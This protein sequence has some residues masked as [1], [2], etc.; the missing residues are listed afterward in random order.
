MVALASSLSLAA[1]GNDHAELE[2]EAEPLELARFEPLCGHDGPV[3]LFAP[4]EGEALEQRWWNDARWRGG[5]LLSTRA[6]SGEACDPFL[7]SSGASTQALYWI[8][9]CGEVWQHVVLDG[10]VRVGPVHAYAEV[11]GCG[12]DGN[13]AVIDLEEATVRTIAAGLGCRAVPFG[14]GALVYR[15]LGERRYELVLLPSLTAPEPNPISLN[16]IVHEEGRPPGRPGGDDWVLLTETSELLLLDATDQRVVS[17]DVDVDRFG[18]GD[19][20]VVWQEKEAF[21]DGLP[22]HAIWLL[23]L[24][25]GERLQV[26]W[27]TLFE[28][29]GIIAGLAYAHADPGLGGSHVVFLP[30]LDSKH[31][32]PGLVP[33][34]R[35]PDDRLLVVDQNTDALALYDFETR[36]QMHVCDARC[37]VMSTAWGYDIQRSLG[38]TLGHRLM[39]FDLERGREIEAAVGYDGSLRVGPR[40]VLATRGTLEGHG[41]L[42]V[43][44]EGDVAPRLIADRALSLQGPRLEVLPAASSDDPF[45]FDRVDNGRLELW[46]VALA[47]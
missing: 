30:E 38:P 43:F 7:S 15:P 42:L 10:S 36:G 31:V 35:S 27:G 14:R 17:I 45:L 39:R 24:A 1:C 37:S 21:V 5:R 28:T 41:D 13:L 40:R 4:P 19:G 34:G 46:A 12:N 9:P 11:L 22:N 6:C 47:P 16:V 2:A 18:L 23:D 25:S 32:P 26:G 3:R 44:D 8:G 20:I 33:R 29:A